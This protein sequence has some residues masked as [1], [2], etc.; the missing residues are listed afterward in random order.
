MPCCPVRLYTL[1]CF[2]HCFFMT[3]KMTKLNDDSWTEMNTATECLQFTHLF[4][5][6]IFKR[7]NADNAIIFLG[8]FHWYR[9][10]VVFVEDLVEDLDPTL[11]QNFTVLF[12]ATNNTFPLQSANALTVGWIIHTD[13]VHDWCILT[14]VTYFYLCFVLLSFG[15]LSQ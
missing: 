7:I 15:T 2:M 14:Y 5:S 12:T 13:Q 1:K 6:G 11:P 4:E 9:C 10:V 3:N 8:R